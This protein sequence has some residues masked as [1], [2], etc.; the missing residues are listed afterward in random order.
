M[1]FSKKDNK[2]YPFYCSVTVYNKTLREVLM[3]L[4]NS[5]EV[6]PKVMFLY[7]AWATPSWK[8][9]HFGFLKPLLHLIFCIELILHGGQ[10]RIGKN[11]QQQVSKVHKQTQS[12]L[13]ELQKITL[14]QFHH[15]EILQVFLC[16]S[17]CHSFSLLAGFSKQ[18]SKLIRLNEACF[19]RKTPSSSEAFLLIVT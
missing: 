4:P 2:Q 9:K 16:R 19:R 5:V 13:E 8:L 15:S 11:Q 3:H 10:K 12:G 6:S 17:V 1:L 7:F 18:S 14:S